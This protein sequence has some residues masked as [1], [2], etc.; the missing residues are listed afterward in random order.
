MKQ[1][2]IGF[3]DSD[4]FIEAVD[5]SRPVN[6]NVGRQSGRPDRKFGILP[7]SLVLTISQ[8]QGDEVLYFECTTGRWNSINGSPMMQDEEAPRRWAVSAFEAAVQ[9]LKEHDIT[10]REALLAMP[11]SLMKMHGDATFLHWNE[12][13]KLYE[14]KAPSTAIA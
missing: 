12:Q 11:I 8:V 14:Y 2:Y 10:F 6:L 9:Y 5:H 7:Q 1:N 3:A 13:S 4:K